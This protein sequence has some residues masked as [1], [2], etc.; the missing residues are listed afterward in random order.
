MADPVSQQ[1]VLSSCVTALQQYDAY[2]WLQKGDRPGDRSGLADAI[3]VHSCFVSAVLQNTK[4]ITQQPEPHV[5]AAATT[6]SQARRQTDTTTDNHDLPAYH[7]PAAEKNMLE[8][9]RAGYKHDSAFGDPA[10]PPR[11]H[12]HMY[13]DGEVWMHNS[14]SIAIP[15]YG[16]IRHDIIT[17]LHDSLYAGHPGERRTI[18]L[19]RRYFWWPGLDHD[20]REHVKGY[21]VCQRGKASTRKTTG[22][23]LQPAVSEGKWQTVCMDF[24]TALPI[25]ARGHDMILTVVDILN[26]FT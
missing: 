12:S 8:M 5:R 2:D 11:L 6:G 3:C 18:S 19:V 9:I 1:M 4:W 25:T 20:C 22:E 7:P 10:D 24:V 26:W 16:N 23:L 13:A 14:G 21:A 15:G 17:E